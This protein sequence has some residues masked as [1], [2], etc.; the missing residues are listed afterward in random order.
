[1]KENEMDEAC[2][3]HAS[4]NFS[5]RKPDRKNSLSWPGG[6]RTKI[7]QTVLKDGRC[8]MRIF[9]SEAA[10]S[11]YSIQ[12]CNRLPDFWKDEKFM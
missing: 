5:P 12:I 10:P 8:E 7:L 6:R 11:L 3:T 1:M 4:N 9:G 2:G